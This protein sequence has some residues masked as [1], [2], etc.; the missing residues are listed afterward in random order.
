M[1]NPGMDLEIWKLLRKKWSDLD[2]S[3]HKLKIDFQ[4]IARP[5]NEQDI[6]AIDVIQH[7]DAELVTETV[8]RSA[9]EAYAALGIAGLSMERL[10]EAYKDILGQLLQQANLPDLALVVS[11]TPTSPAS[12]ELRGHLEKFD[13]PVRSS[14]LVNYRHYYILNALRDK[15]IE[16]AGKGWRSVKAIYHSGDLEFFFEY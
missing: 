5:N 6:M 11:M 4:L 16:L 7:I 8:Q 9:G 13:A 14:V 10:V 12:G 2:G 15:M 3:G 1:N